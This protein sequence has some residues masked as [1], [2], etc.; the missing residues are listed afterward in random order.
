MRRRA[1]LAFG[2]QTALLGLAAGVAKPHATNAYEEPSNQIDLEQRVATVIAAYDAQGNHRT[3]TMVDRQSAEWL[4]AQIRRLAVEPVLEPF[5]LDRIDLRSCYL[6]V[7]DRR[8]DGVPLFDAGFTGREGVT[9]V[10]GLPGS[11]ADIAV[12]ESALPDI[13]NTNP[14]Q[15]DEVEEARRRPYKAVVV[16]T[17]GPNPGLFL[18]NASRFRAPAGPPMLQI[19]S[20]GAAWLH[21][22]AATRAEVTLVA[23]VDRTAAQA[24]NVTAK[25]AGTNRPW[26]RSL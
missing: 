1:F 8:I 24:F 25:I 10:V 4:A 2:S 20:S 15:G 5:T 21:E 6:R 13:A 17:R 18:L 7:A 11:D 19:S 3:G 23:H 16:L 12:V 26:R 22:Q 14:A 9:G